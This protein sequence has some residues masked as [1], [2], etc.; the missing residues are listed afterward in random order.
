[1]QSKKT[2]HP[3]YME[4]AIMDFIDY[5]MED[6]GDKKK[7]A[8]EK[9]ISRRLALKKNKVAIQRGKDIQATRTPSEERLTQRAKEN[10]RRTMAIKIM[11]K[12][13]EKLSAKER[14]ILSTRIRS[15]KAQFQKLVQKELLKLKG[16]QKEKIKEK[17]KVDDDT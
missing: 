12:G 7:S 14:D 3:N 2:N 5:L 10:A 1:M 15:Q 8:G 9:R 17:G 4:G 16:K 6:F 13:P 11:G